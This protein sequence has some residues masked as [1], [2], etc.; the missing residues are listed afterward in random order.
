[1]R[2]SISVLPVLL[3]VVFLGP[4]PALAHLNKGDIV[5]YANFDYINYIAT[6]QRY[7]YF[8]TT[9]GIIVYN[10]MDNHWVDPLTGA[11]GIDSENILKVWV[12]RFDQTLCA[13]TV[14][15]LYQY[16]SLVG[17]WIPI[18]QLPVMDSDDRHVAL[19]Q[20][21]ITP[22]GFTFMPGGSVADS[23]GRAF[24]MHDIVDD[25]TGTVWI[26]T[27]GYGP[28][29]ADNIASPIQF[30][31]FGLL[32]DPTYTL[33]EDSTTIWMAGPI[34]GSYRTGITAFDHDA[35]TFR[36]IES[37]ASFD[38]PQTDINCLELDS[39]SV[40]AG[41][42]VGLFVFD[43]NSLQVTAR[44]DQYH[45]LLDEGVTC[46]KKAGDSLFVGTTA[47]LIV[48]GP[49]LDSITYVA[50]N[51]FLNKIIYDLD[52]V[53]DHLWIATE[54]GAYRLSLSD[55]KLQQFQD[56]TQVL[57]SHVYTVRHFGRSL[58]L[59]ADAGAVQINLD[60]GSTRPFRND[61]ITFDNR[62]LAAN[63]RVMA[64]SSSRGFTLNYLGRRNSRIR[65]F[66]VD[67][68]LPSPRVF[69]LLFDGDYLWVG[70][71]QGVCRFWWNDP[72]RID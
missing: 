31:P 52:F 23:Y 42:A 58:W 67:D 33:R 50:P 16:D 3:A 26:G 36:Y 27:W 59:A 60:S 54:I 62:A 46:L 18:D 66:T 55:G 4:S 38:F 13:Q 34:L 15:G 32:Q 72:Y 57:F 19:P 65:E 44:R 14:A 22:P 11:Y 45:G 51:Q 17:E 69:S 5:N 63:D 40:Y 28:A 30:L 9:N 49:K 1:M 12:D 29:R 43:R 24:P 68:G 2:K 53:D 47:G 20:I 61:Y 7:V 6:S 25:G 21:M 37:G 10:K 56:P 71:D 39:T 64:I 35:N 70:T 8:A 41:T 48:L